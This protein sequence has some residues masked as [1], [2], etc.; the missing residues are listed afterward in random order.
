MIALTNCWP[1]LT[2]SQTVGPRSEKID[3]PPAPYLEGAEAVVSRTRAL[4]PKAQISVIGCFGDEWAN[5][6]SLLKRAYEGSPRLFDAVTIH[7]Y[8]PTNGTITK[9]ARTDAEL[10][11]ATLAAVGPALADTE[12]KVSRDIAAAAPIWLDEFNWGGDWAGVTWPGEGHGAIRG[13]LW[14][15]YT[16]QAMHV[17]Q[18]AQQAG[19]AGFGSLNYYSLF[20]QADNSW[21]RWASCTSV[22]NSAD[23][24]AEVAFDGVSQIIAHMNL[25]ALGKGHTQV[26]MLWGQQMTNATVPASLHPKPAGQSCVMGVRFIGGGPTAD[27]V[28]LN[29]CPDAVDVTLPALP[30]SAD[31]SAAITQEWHYYSGFDVG[32]ADGWTLATQIGS[33]HS[34][35][36][37]NGPLP[38]HSGKNSS[39]ARAVAAMWQQGPDA[40]PLPDPG[41]IA[42]FEQLCGQQASSSSSCRVCVGQHQPALQREGGCSSRDVQSSLCLAAGGGAGTGAV[43]TLPAVSL[44]FM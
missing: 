5:C 41:C 39:A 20:F 11:T 38:V 27:V 10:R 33:L 3:E 12:W 1:I 30:T 4:F 26:Q 34:P 22:S 35:P 14:A 9:H 29:M 23:R 21:A 8:G 32:P 28:L 40:P 13:L 43:L 25:V 18:Y 37:S 15:A 19:R 7:M 17:T 44:S 6:S 24:P 16:I 2:A 42:M 31:T 36:W